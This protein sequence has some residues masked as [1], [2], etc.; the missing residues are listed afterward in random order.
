MLKLFNIPE[1]QRSKYYFVLEYPNVHATLTNKNIK[2]IFQ[3][4]T[5][6]NLYATTFPYV[7][8]L[9]SIYIMLNLNYCIRKTKH[10]LIKLNVSGSLIRSV[11]I[12]VPPKHCGSPVYVT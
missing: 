3:E 5:T 12:I 8:S 7:K 9:A 6:A 4:L 10:P 1:F 11:F 2:I